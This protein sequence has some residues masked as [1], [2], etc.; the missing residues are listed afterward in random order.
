MRMVAMRW[1][2]WYVGTTCLA[3]SA[4]AATCSG[5][6]NGLGESVTTRYSR[7]VHNNGKYLCLTGKTFDRCVAGVSELVDG[8]SHVLSHFIRFAS[9]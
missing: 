3:R 4:Y 1:M 7:H 5:S 6:S 8:K 2:S 9:V